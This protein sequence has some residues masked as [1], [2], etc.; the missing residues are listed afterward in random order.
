MTVHIYTNT[1]IKKDA[2]GEFL[3]AMQRQ[4]RLVEIPVALYSIDP[5][6]EMREEE[7]VKPYDELLKTLQNADLFNIVIFIYSVA[8]H[9]VKEIAKL[10]NPH[11]SKVLYY[12]NVTPPEFFQKYDQGTQ[13]C[14]T[15]PEDEIKAMKQFDFF[16]GITEFTL[17]NLKDMYFKVH[18]SEILEKQTFVLAPVLNLN[19]NINSINIVEEKYLLA[20]GRL[21]PNKKVEDLISLFKE[22][23]EIDPSYKFYCVGYPQFPEYKKFLDEHLALCLGDQKELFY[24]L[25][26]ISPH[27]IQTLYKNAQAFISMSEHEGFCVPILEALKCTIP[28]FAYD[29]GAVREVLGGE[30][31]GA[32]NLFKHKNFKDWAHQIT[33]LNNRNT[34]EILQLKINQLKL[35]LKWEETLNGKEFLHLVTDKFQ[36]K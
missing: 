25:N 28:I 1:L 29:Q 26:D 11:L 12:M 5:N 27:Q 3:L 31:S 32:G 24:F 16:G 30:K 20:V 6:Q 21:A 33:E 13:N 9:R 10:E 14:C 35:L 23:L 4:L 18:H 22:V 19:S 15:I 36:K 2:I 17:S 8:D 7:K 34:T